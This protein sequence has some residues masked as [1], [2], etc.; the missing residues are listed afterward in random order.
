MTNQ[1]F[2]L[3]QP[4]VNCSYNLKSL[5]L[6][7][8]C[9]E[10]GT[11]IRISVESNLL[12]YADREWLIRLFRG[13]DWI[14]KG[15]ACLIAAV[16]ISL[17]NLPL[18]FLSSDKDHLLFSICIRI[19]IYLIYALFI[20]GFF[21]VNGGMWR[22]LQPEPKTESKRQYRVMF[23]QIFV[24]LMIPLILIGFL[25]ELSG[26]LHEMG[27]QPDYGHPVIT[28]ICFIFLL[29]HV[30][31]VVRRYES[32]ERRCV[33]FSMSRLNVLRAYTRCTIALAV[34]AI[35]V[36]WS[37][38]LISAVIFGIYQYPKF[39]MLMSSMA[40]IWFLSVGLAYSTR[41]MVRAELMA[42][43]YFPA[44]PAQPE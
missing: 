9:P 37:I 11:P 3:D 27:W 5:P 34:L 24:I 7:N 15:L 28:T 19:P 41:K 16:I 10:C 2:V 38:P 21:L 43:P 31:Q 25:S 33:S 30:Q 26:Q 23:A 36:T 8:N 20:T 14:V 35:M 40:W 32:L 13:L 44:T 17:L 12:R 18:I 29:I 22:A 6:D 4:C 42:D 39:S 1:A